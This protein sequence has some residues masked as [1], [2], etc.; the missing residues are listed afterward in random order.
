MKSDDKKRMDAFEKDLREA[1][2]KH[3]ID[4]DSL[5]PDYLIAIFIRGILEDF[6]S[7]NRKREEWHGRG[8][9]LDVTTGAVDTQSGRE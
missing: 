9:V 8:K 7:L 6:I 4:G 1:I 5:T 2:N 3:D